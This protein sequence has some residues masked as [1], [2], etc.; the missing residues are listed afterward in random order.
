MFVSSLPLDAPECNRQ[1][2]CLWGLPCMGVTQGLPFKLLTSS[3]PAA[4][5]ASD[6]RRQSVLG[7]GCFF[8][9]HAKPPLGMGRPGD[10]GVRIAS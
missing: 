4:K 7:K 1:L 5:T 9:T 6:G 10:Q 2:V 8:P 3:S